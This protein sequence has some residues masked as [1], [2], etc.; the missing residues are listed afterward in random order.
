MD[1]GKAVEKG[2]FVRNKVLSTPELLQKVEE[3]II[4][5]GKKK[6][7]PLNGIEDFIKGILVDKV[8]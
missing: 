4:Q 8:L 3:E 1:Y 5:T 7:V 6:V 2:T